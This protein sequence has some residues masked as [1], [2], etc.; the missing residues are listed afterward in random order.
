MRLISTEGM[1]DRYSTL[2]LGMREGRVY[3]SE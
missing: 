3:N 2:S 1:M